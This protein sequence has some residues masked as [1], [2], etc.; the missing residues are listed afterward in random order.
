MA[1]NERRVITINDDF[2]GQELSKEEAVT[3]K[4]TYDGKAYELDLSEENARKLD[5]AIAPFLA[6][7]SPV[8]GRASVN[9]AS[10]GAKRRDLDAVRTWAKANGHEVAPRGRVAQSVLDAY[11]AAQ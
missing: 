1:R 3:V 5:E 10:R 7:V 8:G 11:D 2:D 6:N 9:R 4:L